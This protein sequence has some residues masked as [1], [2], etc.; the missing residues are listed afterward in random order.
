LRQDREVEVLAR[1]LRGA[2][3]LIQK[4][5]ARGTGA[6]LERQTRRLS[7][8][9]PRPFVTGVARE[10]EAVDHQRVLAWCEQLRQPYVGWRAVPSGARENVVLG[11]TP[12]GRELTPGSG[13]RLR[14]PAQLDLALEQPIARGAVLRGLSWKRLDHAFPF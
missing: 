2:V 14:R 5:H 6:I 4:G 11:N 8:R 12:A 1:V 3:E 9:R 7:T 10:H 13:D